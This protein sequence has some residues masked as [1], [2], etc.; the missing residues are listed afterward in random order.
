MGKFCTNCGAE[1]SEGFAFCEKCGTPVD[2]SVKAP[3]PAQAPV[4][5]AA[6]QYNQAAQPKRNGMALAGF[7]LSLV[8]V[9]CCLGGLNLFALI[10]SIIG[11]VKAKDYNG[12]RKGL[13]LAGLIIT[14]LTMVI[15][16]VVYIILIATGTWEEMINSSSSSGGY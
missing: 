12:D 4:Q 10:F 6:P 13:A 8:N 14:I 15:S 5:Q 3:T 11:L 7:I 9:F 1:V 2:G 16:V